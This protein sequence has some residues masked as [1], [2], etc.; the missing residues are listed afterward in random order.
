[1]RHSGVVVVDAG[2]PNRI[3]S[4]CRSLDRLGIRATDVNLI[5]LTHAHWDHMGSAAAIKEYTGAPLAVH[6]SEVDWVVDGSPPLPPGI[7][8]WGR[9]FMG[10]HRLFTPLIDVTATEVEI[11]LSGLTWS[12]EEFGVPGKVIHTPGHSRGS[13]SVVLDTGQAFVGDLAMN[14][15]PLTLRP[16]LSILGDDRGRIVAS[17]REVLRHG[18][19]TIYPAHGKPFPAK[20]IRESSRPD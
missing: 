14:R 15:F 6:E 19:K 1:M 20:A 4:F 2:Q 5:L 8:T 9:L 10:V 12:L 18:V 17:W 3:Q 13:V 11:S 7:T 16:S